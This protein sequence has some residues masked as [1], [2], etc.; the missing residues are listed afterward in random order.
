MIYKAPSDMSKPTTFTAKHYDKT[1]TIEIDHSD[2]DL[3][4]VME[5]FESLTIAMGFSKD[6]FRDWVK[7][8]ADVYTQEDVENKEAFIREYEYEQEQIRFSEED[9]RTIIRTNENPPEP[10]EN[11][12]KAAKKYKAN[13]PLDFSGYAGDN[14]EDYQ[15]NID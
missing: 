10:N 11:L 1:I 7:E 5:V 3:N 6:G 14:F 15:N 8:M 13:L 12:K 4:E 9:V 2:I